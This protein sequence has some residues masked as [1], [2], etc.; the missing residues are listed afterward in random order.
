MSPADDRP[1][2]E[3]VDEE[4]V[5][6][7]GDTG[8]ELPPPVTWAG[9]SRRDPQDDD[10]ADAAPAD[11]DHEPDR[12]DEELRA[13]FTE[14]YD[15]IERDL[16]SE[17]AGAEEELDRGDEGEEP[18]PA[19]EAEEPDPVADAQ[20]LDLAEDEEEL[21]RA[22]DE[23]ELAEAVPD[24]DPEP[25]ATI[26]ADTLSLA[27]REQAEEAALAALRARAGG[28]PGDPSVPPPAPPV[29]GTQEAEAVAADDE[30]PA[31]EP[32]AEPVAEVPTVT[33][34]PAATA[35]DDGKTPR[36]KPVWLRF[37]AATL[38]IVSSMAAA[39]AIT[40][41]VFV[42]DLAKGLG[43][44]DGVSKQLDAI[45]GG[46]PQT[47][48]IL[49]SDKRPDD[50]T[51]R[52][53][54]TILLHVNPDEDTISLL[55]I[56]RDLAVRIPGHGRDKFNAA[57]SF[58]GPPLTLKVVKRLTGLPVHH[59]VNINF[60]GFADA[61]NAINCV[62]IDVDRQYYV[63][64]G[65][66][67]DGSEY[68]PIDPPIN[69]GYQKLCGYKA[70]QY[71]RYRIGD[72]DLVRAARQQDFVREARQKIEP[73]RLA[74]DPGYR[75]ELLDVFKEHTT[76]DDNLRNPSEVL[77]LM[78]TFLGASDAVLNEVQFPAQ[79]GT[80][81]VTHDDESL[82]E[83]L[84]EFINGPDAPVTTVGEPVEGD[85]SEGV[86]GDGG[87]G[88]GDGGGG[89]KGGGDKGDDNDA[90]P[91]ANVVEDGQSEGYARQFAEWK[92]KQGKPMIKFPIFYPTA[93]APQTTVT[94][95]SRAFPI[96]GPR[97]YRGYKFVM[98]VP[99]EPDSGL[100][101]EYYGVSGTNWI[102]PPILENPAEVREIDGREYLMFYDGDRLRL[103][104]W[105]TGSGSYWVTNSLLQSLEA[106]QMIAIAT[107]MRELGG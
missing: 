24:T 52:S 60:T 83:A 61:V 68:S 55:S 87:G 99:G 92:T 79:L 62:F 90:Q 82:Q 102:D 25:G 98:E 95:E 46:D 78:R 17:L 53:D 104:G 100:Q 36:A 50:D 11:D 65:T 8:A 77:E 57:Y 48:L 13:G 5:E 47:I 59:V 40:A 96:D 73:Q 86:D 34:A 20:E 76:S 28:T 69:A 88:G 84:D 94:N 103:I 74:V 91:E 12:G 16:D 72:N 37:L 58:G 56:P 38:V 66:F 6:G 63:P 71:V 106:D 2:D 105:K 3:P 43:G 33:V 93:L 7:A 14:E 45:D 1:G 35:E 107:S 101:Q 18:D 44:I 10:P 4:G 27:D 97:E 67:I 39:T 21:D 42:A 23:E 81:Y 41:L 54:T 29:P 30:A 80:T 51:G 49:G 22:D 75:E 85:D 19:D 64:E 9:R 31:E 26:E 70:L 15:Q 32:E 89:K